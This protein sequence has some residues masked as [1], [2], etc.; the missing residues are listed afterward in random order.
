MIVPCLCTYIRS[1]SLF[2]APPPQASPIQFAVS[3]FISFV[4]L[5]YECPS[6]C[7]VWLVT[8]HWTG[9]TTLDWLHH[10]G[11]VTPHWT[12][13]TPL[14]WLHHTGLVTPH[15][16]GY[17]TLDWL[18][19]TGLVT[20]HWTGYTTLDWLHHTGLVT[21][22]WT[23]YITL[24]WLHHTGLVT[25][26]WTGYITL[27]WLHHTGLVTPHWT[28]YITLDWLH[29]TGLVTS[30]WTFEQSQRRLND[31]YTGGIGSFL[32]TLMIVSFLQNKQK[33][34]QLTLDHHQQHQQQQQ[35]APLASTSSSCGVSWNLGAL[36]LEFFQLY[37]GS[38]N[39]YTTAI[40]VANGGR[41]LRKRK[42]ENFDAAG[43]QR[44]VGALLLTVSLSGRP[45]VVHDTPVRHGMTTCYDMLAYQ[46]LSI[47]LPFLPTYTCL[48]ASQPASRIL[49]AFHRLL[50]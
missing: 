36:L 22:H 45:V 18:H 37:G 28:G 9:Y 26:H 1:A 31:T 42:L 24:D 19:H 7:L 11:L 6:P 29:H 34:D 8:P 14:D 30:H 20:S 3:N 32:L 27:D 38:F 41:Y 15:W 10:T 48:P 21:P 5:S 13:Y 47:F 35:G 39:Y 17:T 33:L 44:S 4:V 43:S 40:S 12:G 49:F 46:G 50:K 25:P 2:H 16:T 23:G